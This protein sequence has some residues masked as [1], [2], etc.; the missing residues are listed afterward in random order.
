MIMPTY[1]Y[2]CSKCGRFECVQKITDEPL[3]KCPKCGGKVK[4]LISRNAGI[5]Y[6]ASGFYTTD[7]NRSEEYRKA[8]ESDKSAT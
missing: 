5:I 2:K 6:K 3:D 7:Y 8:A 4:K 1:D